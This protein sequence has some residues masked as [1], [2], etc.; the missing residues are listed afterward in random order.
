MKK[1][2]LLAALVCAAVI[3]TC[4]TN[5]ETGRKGLMLLNSSQEAS[6]GL[7]AFQDIK[8]NTP[9][10]TN[11]SE[12]ALVEKVG[13]KISGVVKLSNAQWEYVCF[14]SEEPNAFCLP[15][16][17][18]GVY[19]A[20]LPITQNEAGLAAVMGHEVAHAT[21]RHGGERMSESLLISLG[22]IALDV[23]MAE[24]PEETRQLALGAYGVGTTL[25]RTLPHSRS[26]ELEA[27]RMGLLYMARAGYDP[28]EAV[29][30]WKRFKDFKGAGG[31]VPAFLSTHPTDDRRIAQLEELMPEAIAEYEKHRK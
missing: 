13:R 6:L 7:S 8:K 26:Q 18:I 3:V 2:A 24:K 30:F 15:G 29:K 4:Y 1:I 14:K 17:K 21:A 9:R 16:G 22:G 25:G 5:P 28:R 12:Q 23:A 19:N 10:T 11:A 27:D 31:S 20:I